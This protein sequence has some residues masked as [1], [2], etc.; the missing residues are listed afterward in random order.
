MRSLASVLTICLLALAGASLLRPALGAAGVSSPV[1]ARVDNVPIPAQRFDEALAK[2]VSQGQADT[3][4]LRRQ[5]REELIARE[6]LR[7]AAEKAGWGNDAEVLKARDEAMMQ[8]Y[9]RHTLH[10]NAVAEAQV[11]A[12][13]DQ[14]VSQLGEKEYRYRLLAVPSENQA[15]ALAAAI[16][17]GK[18]T[19]EEAARA[20]SILPSAKR[21][22]EMDWVSFKLPLTEGQTQ[23]LPLPIAQQIVALSAGMVSAK[24]FACAQGFCLAQLLEARPTRIPTYAE[25]RGALRQALE[26]EQLNQASLKFISG[27]LD[28]ARIVRYKLAN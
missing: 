18:K 1:V 3:L 12:R 6:V 21:G 11:R 23:G 19:F 8:A 27:L 2:A 4:E 25:A 15:L 20:E 24:P 26:S 7:Q 10:P 9:L 22:G 16:A 13:Y 17:A 5:I 28:K 14:I